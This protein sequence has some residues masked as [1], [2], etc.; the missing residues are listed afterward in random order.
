MPD[1]V[2]KRMQFSMPWQYQ[3]TDSLYD[4]DR[5]PVS[6]SL[7]KEYIN[8]DFKSLQQE[9]WNKVHES[10]QVNTAIRGVVGR[11][12]G[13]GFE[14][15][16]EI[17][18][19]QAVIDE[20]ENDPRNRLYTYWP[21][22]VGRK[23]IEGE[24]F[25]LLSCHDDSFI[26]V[27]FV[28][29]ASIANSCYSG[30][31]IIFHPK[32]PQMPLF[33]DIEIED[34]NSLTKERVQ[35]P[36]IYVARYP[37]LAA[38]AAKT[39]YFKEDYAKKSM[40][41]NKKFKKFGGFYK[42]IV[43]WDNGFVTQRA[44]SHLRT[45]L[46]WLNH[47]E[48]LKKW[49]IDHKKS[50]GAYAWVVSFEDKQAFSLWLSLSDTERKKTGLMSKMTPGGRL[51]LPPGMSIEPKNPKLTPI[52][53]QDADILQM[54]VSG[55]NEDDSTLMGSLNST[56]ASAKA[57]KG[58]ASDRIS[59]EIAFFDRFLKYD[60]WSAVFFLKSVLSGFP[61]TFSVREAV[62]FR[63][64][65][66]VFKKVP[67]KPEYLIDIQYPVSENIDL[68]QRARALLGVKHSN[69]NATLGVPYKIMADK[70]GLSGYGRMRLK[71]A[72]EEDK[73]PDLMIEA[74]RMIDTES[75]QELAGTGKKPKRKDKTD[76]TVDDADSDTE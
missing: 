29:P 3:D 42:F 33:Y 48:N 25:L 39:S 40:S 62:E 47:Y 31:G 2:L 54:V 71:A 49:E 14:T 43:S 51:F 50:S 23:A 19:I 8:A 22:Y 58:P 74:D 36:S 26:E 72:T 17:P 75:S 27:D 35:I 52:S 9:C 20:V 63:N 69:V 70:L 73:Y 28:D 15:S 68:E 41:S 59:D 21:K 30:S 65:E 67:K 12:T 34:P 37:E 38:V 66:A 16:S 7:N 53:D 32:K 10:P 55:L 5:F 6:S 18:E 4:G 56:Y 11:L 1:E 44:V 13:L 60:F 61:K 45:T 64:K 57:S 76:T 46:A 24:L